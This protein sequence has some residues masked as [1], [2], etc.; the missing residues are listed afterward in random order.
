MIVAS[1]ETTDDQGDTCLHI[2]LVAGRRDSVRLLLKRGAAVAAKGALGLRPRQMAA[3]SGDP[4]LERLVSDADHW[5]DPN[6]ASEWRAVSKEDASQ[7][8]P[9]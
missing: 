2:A 5:Y 4:E 1:L 7:Q 3:A 9:E 8:E 6:I